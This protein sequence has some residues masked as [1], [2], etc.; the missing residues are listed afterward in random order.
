[1][2]R[3]TNGYDGI[4][5]AFRLIGIICCVCSAYLSAKY[6]LDVAQSVFILGIY[7]TEK[8]DYYDIMGRIKHED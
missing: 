5:T 2:K 3:L 8:G 1:M 6:D 7:L 4:S